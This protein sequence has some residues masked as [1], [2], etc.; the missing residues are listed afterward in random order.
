MPR[1]KSGDAQLGGVSFSMSELRVGA[2]QFGLLSPDTVAKMS[3][4][5]VRST[6]IYDQNTFQANFHA[7]NDP[8]M[9]VTDKDQRCYT[10]KAGKF[11]IKSLAN[12]HVVSLSRYGDLSGSFRAH[13]SQQSRLPCRTTRLHH[14]G[15][16]VRM[17]QL[18]EAA[19]LQSEFQH[20]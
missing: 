9:G 19:R 3:V 18:L 14:Q 15:P 12:D 11:L 16:Q 8:R 6:Q 2:L 5:E 10:C 17:L 4:A 7:V 1:F 20:R 13:L